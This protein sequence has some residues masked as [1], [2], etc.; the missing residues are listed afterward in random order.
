MKGPTTSRALSPLNL[1]LLATGSWFAALGVQ[2]VLFTWLVTLALQES[3]DKVGLAQFTMMLPTLGLILWAGVAADRLGGA[4]LAVWA[5]SF[6]LVPVGGLL[7]L[8]ASDVLS[9]S[10]LLVYAL[11]MGVVQ[12]F[13]TP[14]RDGLIAQLAGD[15]LQRAVVKA[16]LV[17]FGVQLLG[18]FVAGLTD[19]LGPVVV[20]AVQGAFL[21]FGALCFATLRRRLP[22]VPRKARVEESLGAELRAGIETVFAVPAL[23]TVVLLNVAV[24]LLFMGAFQVALPLLA[25][26]VFQAGAAELAGL[27]AV[28]VLGAVATMLGLLRYGDVRRSGRLLL[29]GVFLG[30]LGLGGMALSPSFAWVLV[31]NFCWGVT[32]GMVMSMARALMQE[33]APEAQRGRVMAFFTLTFMGAGPLGALL[34][35]F[36]VEA[37]GPRDALL[38]PAGLMTGFVLWVGVRSPLWRYAREQR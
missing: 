6:S 19:R 9:Y 1:Y 13:L 18:F 21:A 34:S 14:A 12:A 25:R 3:P 10:S 30:V 32:G 16:S 23:R 22:P 29:L 11:A 8:L 31:F 35:G 7:V 28:H 17:Q 33:G 27:N 2:T 26:D 37:L 38:L 15:R 5:Q 24:G 4:R 36:W 20:L